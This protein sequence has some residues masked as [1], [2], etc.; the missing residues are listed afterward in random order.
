M[1]IIRVSELASGGEITPNSLF[2]MSSGDTNPRTSVS[3]TAEK[4][5]NQSTIRHH[6]A[7]YSTQTQSFTGTTGQTFTFNN[8]T[9][10]YGISIVN[11]R[12]LKVSA[13]GIYNLQFST[14]FFRTGGGSAANVYIWLRKNGVN[15]SNTNTDL[16]FAN[17]GVYMVAA[18]NFIQ[19]LTTNDYLELMWATTD[20]NIIAQYVTNPTFGPEVPSIIIT[21][22]QA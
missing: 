17:N 22:T 18:W 2:L 7:Y 3:I 12:Q 13:P 14:Q 9:S 15:V 11:N 6:A 5:L 10:E 8:I 4:L 1:S 16:T 20:T 21:L 19:Q